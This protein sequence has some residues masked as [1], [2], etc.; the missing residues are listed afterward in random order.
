MVW[1]VERHSRRSTLIGAAH[2]FP[3]HFKRELRRWM[4]D[5]RIVLLE[6]PL[7]P[8]ATKKVLDAGRGVG[9]VELYKA[10][11][12]R[13]HAMLGIYS[14]P[15]DVNRMLRDLVFG[16]QEEWLEQEL[17]ALKPWAAFFGI[18]TRFRAREGW[19]H[20]LDLDAA[21]I[22]AKLGKPVRY[23]EAIEEQIAALE[24]VPVERFAR[25]LVSGDWRGYNE[26]YERHYLDGD[27]EGL[28][29]AA[30]D[31]PTYCE[32]VIGTRDAVLA[33][34]MAGE[35]E[36]GDACVVIGVAHCLGVLGKLRQAG[37]QTKQIKG[38]EQISG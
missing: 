3:R 28:A 13:I 16:R 32:P 5:A 30:E 35:L 8:V 14:A 27:L 15:L 9:G 11:R 20:K 36:T 21:Q 18:W 1:E 29:A 4:A 26:A 19:E 12:E 34:R 38:S 37:Y 24:A 25:F 2:F 17:R 33:E 6:G 7:N 22:A 10:A 23:L 31:F